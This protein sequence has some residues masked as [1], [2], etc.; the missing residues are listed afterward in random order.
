VLAL[1][2]AEK[3]IPLSAVTKNGR[4]EVLCG[5]N[6]PAAGQDD[7]ADLFRATFPPAEPAGSESRGGQNP[8]SQRNIG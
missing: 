4:A 5:H 2:A 8:D 3:N 6:K 1:I 7:S